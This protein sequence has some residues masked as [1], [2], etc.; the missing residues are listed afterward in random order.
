MSQV[1]DIKVRLKVTITEDGADLDIS[2]AT[3]KTIIITKPDGTV[4]TK[5]ATFLTDG[6]EGI[7]YYD[8]VS[9][10]LDQS[11]FYKIQ[12]YIEISGGSYYGSIS[13][14]KVFCNLI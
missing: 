10:D 1:D 12:G 7:I 8:T 6:T 5:T 14:F 4:L 13:T 9:G 11:G 3:V 2:T